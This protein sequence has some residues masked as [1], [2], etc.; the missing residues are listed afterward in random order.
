MAEGDKA[1]G[2]ALFLRKGK[3]RQ[4]YALT[5]R[6]SGKGLHR[7]AEKKKVLLLVGK[8]GHSSPEPIK[9][10]LIWGD[11][12]RKKNN[13]SE[14]YVERGGGLGGGGMA[15]PPISP[16]GKRGVPLISTTGKRG[17]KKQNH[18]SPQVEKYEKGGEKGRPGNYFIQKGKRKI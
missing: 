7:P 13:F 18:V 8:G 9:R 11:G 17:K 10:H 15:G 1:G 2:R 4:G 6:R 3:R 14:Y 5:G 16:L 12:K